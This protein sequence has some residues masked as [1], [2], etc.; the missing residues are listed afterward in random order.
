MKHL[1]NKIVLF[2]LIN[3]LLSSSIAFAAE[4]SVAK[5]EVEPKPEC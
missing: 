3:S 4:R 5:Q 1:I 2:L